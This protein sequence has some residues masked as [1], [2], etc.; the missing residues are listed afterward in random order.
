MDAQGWNG[1]VAILY[2]DGVICYIFML[3]VE[4]L[5]KDDLASFGPFVARQ[6]AAIVATEIVAFIEP[7]DC[8]GLQFGNTN[9]DGL[10]QSSHSCFVSMDESIF[11]DDE[12]VGR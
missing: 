2:A 7:A 12:Q 8:S 5:Q 1:A 9:A 3:E 10:L 6:N 11:H 4:F